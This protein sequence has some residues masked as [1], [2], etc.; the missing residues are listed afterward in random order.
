MKDK[1]IWAFC[2]IS[3]LAII[4]LT[5]SPLVTPAGVHKPVFM[6]MPYTLWVGI[7]VALL[8]VGLT[9]LGTRVHPGREE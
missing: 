8:L 1:Q 3:V 2:K 7:V 9:W 5:F 6:G 4:V